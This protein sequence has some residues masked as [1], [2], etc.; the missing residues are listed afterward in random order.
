MSLLNKAL[1]DIEQRDG[2]HELALEPTVKLPQAR[3]WRNVITIVAMLVSAMVVIALAYLLIPVAPKS[4][5]DSV[6]E[7]TV[8]DPSHQAKAPTLVI[9]ETASQ[10]KQTTSV[11]LTAPKDDNSQPVSAIN[12]EL[13]SPQHADVV[14]NEQTEPPTS[15]QQ[16]PSSTK[17]VE[18]AQAMVATEDEPSDKPIATHSKSPQ[19]EPPTRAANASQPVASSSDT[20]VKVVKALSVQQ[21]AQRWFEQGQ[22]SLRFA[23]TNEAI[24]QFEQAVILVPEHE[25]ARSSLAATLYG[26]QRLEEAYSVLINGLKVAPETLSWRVM[27]AKMAIEQQQYQRVL[28]VLGDGQNA[29]ATQL[30]N[31]D[32]WILKGSAARQ[33]KQHDIAKVCFTEL[34]RRQ[35]NVAKWW[36]ALATSEDALGQYHSARG[37]YATALQLGGLSGPSQQYA[38]AR[39]DSLQDTP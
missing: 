13:N 16:L 32:Y 1:K 35:P 33:L 6:E 24:K 25:Q 10:P 14:E 39:Y 34:V 9:E 12:A 4:T 20:A 36:L 31:N 26:Q 37:H 17:P 30:G 29:R 15:S 5:S 2:E 38:R 19:V 3:P 11:A 18:A 28:E 23:M 7:A 21:R 8:A 27:I 22:Q